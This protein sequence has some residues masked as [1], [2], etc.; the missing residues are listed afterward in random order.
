MGDKPGWLDTLLRALEH[1][2]FV[3]LTIIVLLLG[4]ILLLLP[5][6]ASDFLGAFS[7]PS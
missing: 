7:G 4:I 1:A 3:K 5:P 2:Q 6:G